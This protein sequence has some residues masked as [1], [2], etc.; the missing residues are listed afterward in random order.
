MRSRLIALTVIAAVACGPARA[1]ITYQYTT[2]LATY[3]AQTGSTVTVQLYLSEILTSSSSSII[4]NDNG[5]FG[6]GVGVNNKGGATTTGQAT[7]SSFTLNTAAISAGG[8]G[9]GGSA[10]N[11]T[12]VSKDGSNG[13]L[14]ESIGPGLNAGPL[15][16]QFSNSNGTVINRVLLGTATITAGVAGNSTTFTITSLF[17]SPNT[18]L[19][20]GNEDNT[21]TVKSGWDLDADNN[22]GNPSFI[23][24]ASPPTYAGANDISNT[25]IVT[26]T[27]TPEPSSLVLGAL[28]AACGLALTAWKHWRSRLRTA[29]A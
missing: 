26:A 6:A 5:M 1:S 15:A 28:G 2:D 17:N 14:I 29:T 27:A 3:T 20:Q 7:I 11:A 23:T 22:G 12:D 16:S 8:F 10:G 21:L 19:G 13:A 4:N 18:T 24:G 25:F 9:S